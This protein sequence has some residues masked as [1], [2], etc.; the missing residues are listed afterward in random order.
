[1]GETVM[2]L[3]REKVTMLMLCLSIFMLGCAAKKEANSDYDNFI[4]VDVFDNVANYQGLQSGWFAMLIKNKFN[5]EINMIAPN[6]AGGGGI[7]FDIREAAGNVGDLVICSGDDGNLQKLV[8]AGLVVDIEPYLADK[9]IMQYEDAIRKLNSGVE[10]EGIYGI[11]TEVSVNSPLTPSEILEP[12]YGAYLRW[13]LYG[14]LGYPTISTLED[15]LPVLKDMQELEPYNQDGE[16]TYAFSFFKDW[17]DNMM[18]AAKQPCCFYGYDEYGFAL[19]KA[20]GSDYQSI[21]DP[22]SVYIRVLKW[23]FDANQLGLVDPESPIQTYEGMEDKYRDGRLLYSPWPWVAQAAYNTLDRKE[24]G[25]GFML[26]DIEDMQIYSYGCCKDGESKVILAVGSQ[27]EDPERLADFIDWLY[28]PEGIRNSNAQTATD[29]IGPKGLCW[30]DG[31]DG[32]YLT[33]L[34]VEA[35][36]NGDAQLPQ[37]WGGGSWLEGRSQLN[38]NTVS[39]KEVDENGYSYNY[40]LWESVMDMSETAIDKDW[41]ERMGAST[42]MEYL[43][44]NNKLLVSP[45]C[46]FYSE[47]E[48]AEENTIRKQC[49]KAIQNYSWQMVF[50]ENEEEFYRL[51]KEM[52]TE[53]L[54]LGYEKILELDQMNAQAREQVKRETAAAY[55]NE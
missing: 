14:E 54:S 21:I 9:K 8:N 41:K 39:K 37:E 3:R 31:I 40:H 35:I 48:R 10:K 45:G 25:K 20:D 13:D 53:V 46:S 17:D 26:V 28:S 29:A 7:L 2:K 27:A 49:K 23:Y 52:R 19:V 36:L 18:N 47:P 43:E 5:M 15:L 50:A 32:P 22:D 42:T 51:Y 4:V 16:K 1:M 34:G 12:T 24:E 44:K 38:I 33:E 30:D 6:V 55:E 11:P